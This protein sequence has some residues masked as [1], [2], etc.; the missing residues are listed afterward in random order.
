M[1]C[2]LAIKMPFLSKKNYVR[3]WIF[4]TLWG[5]SRL[6]GPWRTTKLTSWR[7]RSWCRPWRRA[8]S[9]TR[10][11][12][13]WGGDLELGGRWTERFRSWRGKR[14]WRWKGRFRTGRFAS[15]GGVRV[16]GKSKRAY[17]LCQKMSQLEFI[18]LMY[19]RIKPFKIV[20]VELIYLTLLRLIL[21]PSEHWN[22]CLWKPNWLCGTA[23]IVRSIFQHRM[24]TRQ[25]SRYSLNAKPSFPCSKHQLCSHSPIL[26]TLNRQPP[27]AAVFAD[28]N[29]CIEI[30]HQNFRY[31]VVY[32]AGAKGR[33]F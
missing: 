5:Y 21:T 17:K 10:G 31:K 6:E 12:I 28:P 27:P 8:T 11:A 14:L 33:R 24:P 4:A 23:H 26:L 16:S 22:I 1:N 32:P 29:G 3:L 18:Q 13:S 25:K 30:T 2:T 19:S 9:S 7:W 15:W 20:N